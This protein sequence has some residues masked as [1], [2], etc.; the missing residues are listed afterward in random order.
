[1]SKKYNSQS[2]IDDIL[3]VSAKL[4]LEK[5]FDKTS[6]N[7]IATTA[8]ISKGAIYH[9]FQ[10]KDAIIKAV[11]EKKA[12]VIKETMNNWLSEMNS[13]NGK[14]KLQAIL[15]KNL[16]SQETHYLDDV[17]NT[18]MKSAEFVLAYMQDCVCKD[19]H[20]ISE[21]IKQGISDGSLATDYPD[22]CAEVFLLLINVWCDPAVFSCNA[23]KL[24]LRLKFLQN[25]MMSIGID[26]L[27]DTIIQK[28]TDLL[29][30]LY[31]QGE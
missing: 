17:M 5:G 1:M 4:F 25:M 7:D 15:E 22:E 6:M 24:L 27:T 12:Q 29:H 30:R 2:T 31:P 11:T 16:D 3:S 9:H 19:S 10:S 8:G 28:L 26:V 21:I 13:L 23:D 20:L 18:R 14:E